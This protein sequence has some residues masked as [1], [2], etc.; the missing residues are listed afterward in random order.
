M[1]G[2]NIGDLFLNQI[3]AVREDIAILLDLERRR[4]NN[5]RLTVKQLITLEN[6][7]EFYPDASDRI[8]TEL[9]IG[10]KSETEIILYVL[11]CEYR[12]LEPLDYSFEEKDT[13]D[14]PAIPD[15]TTPDDIL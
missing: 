10:E 11:S 12:G 7:R 8:R 2:K 9:L 6:L 5:T 1:T 13:E 3:R 4:C 15:G 14:K